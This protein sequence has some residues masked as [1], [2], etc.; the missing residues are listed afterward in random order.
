MNSVGPGAGSNVVQARTP[1]R[2]RPGRR[3]RRVVAG[4]R[5]DHARRGRH[6]TTT[7]SRSPAT[8]STA[9]PAARSTR[10]P[11]R[12]PGTAFPTTPDTRCASGRATRSAAGRGAPPRRR[13][14]PT[15]RR[16][17]SPWSSYGDAQ[18]Q[19]GCSTAGCAY[20]RARGTGFTPGATVT[21]TCHG[22][23]QGGFSS[24]ARGPPTATA[25]SSTTP[26]ATSGTTSQFWISMNG[27]ESDHRQW[28]G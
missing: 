7:A 28:P 23:V 12:S 8:R 26:P 14:T 24:T 22:A 3:P 21:V 16:A 10:R 4:P 20:V 18:G 25:S 6:R 15:H 11:R 17:R 27:V 5:R 13:R 19:P 2:A 9:T 1:G